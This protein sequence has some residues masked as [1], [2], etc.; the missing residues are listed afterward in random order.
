MQESIRVMFLY[1]SK[2]LIYFNSVDPVQDASP[3][4]LYCLSKKSSLLYMQAAL[5]PR[6]YSD[7]PSL[8]RS[9]LFSVSIF[10][11]PQ[12][13]FQSKNCQSSFADASAISLI[14]GRC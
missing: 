4:L 13:Y 1:P 14:I 12:K 7:H 10:F 5:N 6:K 2:L 3:E 11:N 8:K 9:E